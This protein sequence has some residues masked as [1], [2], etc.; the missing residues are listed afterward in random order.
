[1]VAMLP[2][3]FIVPQFAHTHKHHRVAP[4]MNFGE[5]AAKAA[6]LANLAQPS[7]G[8]AGNVVPTGATGAALATPE[9]S[10]KAAW[11]ASIEQQPSWLA[12]VGSVPAPMPAGVA[13]DVALVHEPISYFSLDKL[14]PK[15]T[16]RSQGGLVDVGEPEDFSRPISDGKW[17]GARVGSWA[18]T[19][20]GWNSPKLRPTTEVFL[21]YDGE[22][23]V[24]DTD[25]MRHPFG[26]G[27]VVVLPK[28]WSG[29]WDIVR[30]IHKVWVVHEHSDVPGAADGIVRAHVV[31]VP[32]LGPHA[33]SPYVGGPLREAP[34]HLSSTIYHVGP[35]RVGF[36]SCAPG[37]FA[38]GVRPLSE[39]FFVVDGTCF[40]T[41]PD[42][43]GRRC[44]AGDTLVLP[45]GWAGHWDVVH[46][47]TMVFVEV[48]EW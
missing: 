14:K 22:G 1:M 48:N 35:T 41:A 42:G 30:Q 12:S 29:R 18:C 10:D 34:A 7:W 5:E 28:H 45:Q 44:T 33:S 11:L 17:S 16:R 26:P 19:A 46:P 38:V 9:D 40:L 21:V 32:G 27:D 2:P 47:T 3:T 15:G 43:S 4:R 24:T 6:W 25:G 39:A 20:G 13:S 37:S 8:K 31:P 36:L 23:C